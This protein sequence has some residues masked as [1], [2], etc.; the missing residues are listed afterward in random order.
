MHA[1]VCVSVF[2]YKEIYYKDLVF[3]IIKTWK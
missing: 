3:A 1:S 2:V